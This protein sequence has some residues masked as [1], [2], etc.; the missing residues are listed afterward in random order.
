MAT[1]A[2]TGLCRYK[3]IFQAPGTGVHSIRFLGVAAVDL[4]LTI[5]GALLLSRTTGVS[6]W[7]CITGLLAAGVV[8]HRVFCVDTALNKAIFGVNA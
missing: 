4:G 5:V 6:P 3:D 7:L 2:S 8:A 1:P